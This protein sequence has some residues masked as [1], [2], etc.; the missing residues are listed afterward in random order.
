MRTRCE[1]ASPEAI[2][3][4]LADVYYAAVQAFGGQDA[5]PGKRATH[6][7]L[8]AEYEDKLA[9]YNALLQEAIDEGLVPANTTLAKSQVQEYHHGVRNRSKMAELPRVTVRGPQA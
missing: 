5:T 2:C 4:S 9:I 8:I 7:D 6:A 1:D 3:N